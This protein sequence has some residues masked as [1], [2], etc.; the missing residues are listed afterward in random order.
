MSVAFRWTTRSYIPEDRNLFELQLRDSDRDFWSFT[1]NHEA[2]R[3]VSANHEVIAVVQGYQQCEEIYAPPR[4]PRFDPRSGH[5]RFVVGK[6]ALG[7]IFSQYLF[8]LPILIPP[9]A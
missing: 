6:V 8:P 5:V 1:V 9:T 7:Q 3:L 4:R 2:D